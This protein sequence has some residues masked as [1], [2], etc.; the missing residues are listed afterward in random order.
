M[1]PKISINRMTPYEDPVTKA[2]FDAKCQMLGRTFGF[3][4]L[5][6]IK[7]EKTGLFVGF[8]SRGGKEEGKYYEY[9]Y[10]DSKTKEEI[11]R[12]AVAAYHKKLKEVKPAA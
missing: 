8:P 5:K 6:L 7:S 10:T 9:S 1:T 3:N 11:Q 4:D 12:A 2:F